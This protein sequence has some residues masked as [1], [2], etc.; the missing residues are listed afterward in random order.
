MFK[1]IHIFIVIII[2]I[3]FTGMIKL[4][5]KQNPNYL[6]DKILLGKIMEKHSSVYAGTY[7]NDEGK[8]KI[9]LTKD[10]GSSELK[11]IQSYN[12]KSTT[13]KD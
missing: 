3:S 7:I 8:Q 10:I 9:C 13:C 11:Q 5:S 12:R 2:L 4:R 6:N 1:K